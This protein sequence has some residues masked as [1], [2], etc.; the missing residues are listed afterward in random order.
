ML[1]VALPVYVYGLTGSAAATA[2][3]FVVGLLPGLALSPVAG[4]LADRWDRRRT[5]LAVSLAQAVVLAPL[6][7]VDGPGQLWIVNAVTAAQASLAALFEPARHALVPALVAPGAAGGG[8]R[9]RRARREPRAADR[10]VAGRARAGG[11]RAARRPARRRDLVRARRRAARPPAGPRA[12]A[13]RG[14][15]GAAG[16]ARGPARDPRPAAAAGDDRRRRPD[17][18]LPGDLRRPV[19]RLRDR[20]PRRRRGRGR[21]AARRAGGRRA[22]RR[23]AGRA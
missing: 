13:G 3:T 17:G 20:P 19:R 10:R 15:P 1:R 11:G 23:R 18:A 12:H 14:R 22:A 6:L 8:E 4:V 9:A 5:M 7:A 2:A 16:V 21:R